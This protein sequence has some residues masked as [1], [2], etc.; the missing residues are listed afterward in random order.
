MY[1]SLSITWDPSCLALSESSIDLYLNIEEAAGL[2]AV[3]EWTGIEFSSG[4]LKT[5]L[6]P[7]WWNASTGAGQVSGQVSL[8]PH[9]PDRRRAKIVLGRTTQ[10]IITA[11]GSP[12]W[13]TVAPAGPLF[14]IAYN[15][16]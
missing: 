10:L 5:Q 7:G 3:H 4:A 13:D 11:H 15:G 1:E 9:H 14:S 2:T 6:N 8:L 16:T 12:I